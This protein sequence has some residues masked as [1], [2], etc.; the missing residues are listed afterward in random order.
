[1]PETRVE[2]PE[3]VMLEILSKLPVKSLTRFRCVCKPWCSSFQTP[4]FI[5]KHQ[6]NNLHNN[7]LNLLLKRCQ[8]NTHDD[9]Y[10]L[11]QLSTEKSQNFSVQHNI[12]LPFFEDCWYA[13]VVSGPCNGLLCLHDADKVALWNP[14]TREF[15]T[16]PQSTV[17]RPPLVDSTSFGC[18]GIGFDS[19]S[20]D[21]KVV[22]FVTNYFEENED[23]GLMGD[24]N[25]QVELYSLKSDSWKEISVPGVQP[26]GSPLFNNYVNGFYYWQAIGDSDYLILS[27]DMVNEKF[28][29]LPLPEFGG[30]LAKYYLELL[31]FN[32]LLGAIVYPREGTDKSFD[33]WVMNGSW[34]KQFRIDSLPGVERP[35]GFWKNGEL[36]LESSDHELVLFDPSTRELKSLDIH[37]YQETMQIIAYVESLVPINGRSEREELIIRRPAGDASN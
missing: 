1:M 26:Y 10:Y 11:S 21:Y 9:I 29:T 4:H 17:Q 20:G 6:Q 22:R 12:H 32:G 24:W 13:P 36:F 23:E 15:K 28:S 3:M 18:V 16:L 2:V 31:D 30:S 14:S 25:H 34:T 19:Q 7:N 27:F 33:L 35:L 8:G 37:A 5:T